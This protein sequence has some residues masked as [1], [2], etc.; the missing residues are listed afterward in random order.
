MQFQVP[1][2]RD[3]CVTADG[4]HGSCRIMSTCVQ[5]DFLDD[6][7]AFLGFFCPIGRY[8]KHALLQQNGIYKLL[9]QDV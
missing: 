3:E 5:S 9:F 4:E 7:Q 6:Y 2:T 1:D 8:V